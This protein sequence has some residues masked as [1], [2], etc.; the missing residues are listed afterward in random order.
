MFVQ[1]SKE[2]L[3]TIGRDSFLTEVIEIAGAESVTA[4]VPS[5]YPKLSKETATA[6][7]PAAIILSKSEDNKE[8]NDAFRKS[9]AVR[10][11]FIYRIDADI[12]SRPGPRTVDALELIAGLLHR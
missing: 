1:I 4:D 12:I 3:F 2:P 11:G 10:H 5:G 8:P 7:N 6:L 9:E